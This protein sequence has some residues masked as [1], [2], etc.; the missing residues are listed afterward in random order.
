MDFGAV[1]SEF[2]F[3]ARPT[4][5]HNEERQP[6]KGSSNLPDE[7]SS[8]GDRLS[9]HPVER[10]YSAA[11]STG[12]YRARRPVAGTRLTA[13]EWSLLKQ[14]VSRQHR[15]A[16]QGIDSVVPPAPPDSPDVWL[17]LERALRY[18][19]QYHFERAIQSAHL[20]DSCFASLPSTVS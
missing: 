3:P 15:A 18:Y 2:T 10:R 16:T 14:V 9:R 12:S 7:A 20:I 13:D 4:L 19:A 6:S 11:Q 1:E 8:S 5:V 17:S